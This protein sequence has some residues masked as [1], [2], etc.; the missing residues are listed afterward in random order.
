MRGKKI[1]TYIQGAAVR[2]AFLDVGPSL[3]QVLD[4]LLVRDLVVAFRPG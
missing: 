4:L 2:H 3:G 1:L